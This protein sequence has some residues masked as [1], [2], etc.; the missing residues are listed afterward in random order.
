MLTIARAV[1]SCANL[2]LL[3][4]SIV[5]VKFTDTARLTVQC[6]YTVDLRSELERK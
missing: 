5:Y 1:M 6:S 4:T 2:H 3:Q